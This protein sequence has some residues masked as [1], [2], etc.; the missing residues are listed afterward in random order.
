MGTPH[1][2]ASRGD[3]AKVVLMPGDPLRAKVVAERYLKDVRCFNRVR[4]M[5]GYTG[6]YQGKSVSVMGSGMGIPSMG[7]YSYEL[8]NSYDVDA[9]IRIGTVGG[10]GM[11]VHVRDV[12]LAQGACTDSNFAYQYGCPGSI[13]PL[14]DFGMLR[15]AAEVAERLGVAYHAGNVLTSDV[16]YNDT[17]HYHTWGE[18]SVLG[19]EME[20]AGLYLTATRARKKALSILT[21]S[22]HV[23]TGESL[24]ALERQND[25]TRMMEIALEVAFEQA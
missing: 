8:Y 20:T 9:I 25:F 5:L 1:N 4:N 21:V 6:T 17:K 19:V 7:I 11:N 15:K 13:A 12:V 3:I 2:D 22:D 16:F 24:S 14:G 18:M 23:I 10:I